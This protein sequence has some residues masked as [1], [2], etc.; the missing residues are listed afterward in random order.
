MKSPDLQHTWRVARSRGA[1]T[2]FLLVLLGVW[3]ALVPFVGPYFGYGYTSSTWD[4]TWGRFWLEI[5][6]GAAA[7]VGGLWLAASASRV[8][9]P[10]GGWLAAAAGAWFVLGTALSR[11]WGGP[12]N[13]GAP[14][15]GTTSR[16][17][18][19]IG[20]FSGLGVV[21]VFLAALAI[22][23]FSVQGLRDIRAAEK[24]RAT[25]YDTTGYDGTSYDAGATH[26]TG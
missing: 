19:Q 17:V 12:M 25:G 22:G 20:L 7:I 8:T 24:R 15:G 26:S 23:R 5:L 18:A 13:V 1:V 3:G 4:F 2:G 16:I 14:S 11:L 10:A 21:I 9:G 6:P